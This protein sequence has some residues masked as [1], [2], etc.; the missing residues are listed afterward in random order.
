MARNKM[1]KDGSVGRLAVA[2]FAIA[3]VLAIG[4]VVISQSGV[5]P[6]DAPTQQGGVG[7]GTV[8]DTP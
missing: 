8:S 4:W 7:P 1:Q 2:V 3:L 5:I 6:G